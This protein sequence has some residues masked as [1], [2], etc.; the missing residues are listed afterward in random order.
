M[1]IAPPG[2]GNSIEVHGRRVTNIK[3]WGLTRTAGVSIRMG[4]PFIDTTGV[5][6]FA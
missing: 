6:N 1:G 5:L 2:D 3:K 4:D